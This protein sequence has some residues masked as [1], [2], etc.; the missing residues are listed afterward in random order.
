VSEPTTDTPA[1]DPSEAYLEWLCALESE[2]ESAFALSLGDL[3]DMP[4][5]TA[6]DAGTTPKEFFAATLVPTLREV[7]GSFVDACLADVPVPPAS[8]R[9]S[10]R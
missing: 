2:S 7:H 9:P 5:R 4:T 10:P 1:F 3:P 6:F 8:V